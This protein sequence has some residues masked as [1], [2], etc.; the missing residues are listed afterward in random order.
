M[1]ILKKSEFWITTF[2]TAT[3]YKEVGDQSVVVIGINYKEVS[4]T[5]RASNKL[6]LSSPLED[7]KYR[8]TIGSVMIDYDNQTYRYETG[9]SHAIRTLIEAYQAYQMAC[10]R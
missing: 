3:K 9:E 5:G 7:L 2:F 8:A 10:P 1:E 4:V 6:I